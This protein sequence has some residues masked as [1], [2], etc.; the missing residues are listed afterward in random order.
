MNY[1]VAIVGLVFVA[2]VVLVAL[3]GR[4]AKRENSEHISNEM[5]YIYTHTQRR[6]EKK[7]GRASSE[8]AQARAT[9]LSLVNGRASASKP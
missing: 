4:K 2:F 5:A 9:H 3:R 8:L 7:R 6:H 1:V